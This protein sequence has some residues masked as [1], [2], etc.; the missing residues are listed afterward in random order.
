[1]KELRVAIVGCGRMGSERARLAAHLGARVVVVCDMDGARAR[2]L[3]AQYPG[4][5]PLDD[6]FQ[7]CWS[8]LEAVFVCTPP[9]RRGPVELAAIEAGVAVF[10][11]KPVGLCAAQ[12]DPLLVAL[13]R[14]P[15][16]T[17]VGYMNRY[18]RSVESARQVLVN[19]PVLGL[20][21]N[22]VGGM[23]K[24]PWWARRE[25]SG[26]QINEQCTHL[27]DLS[28]YL[29]GEIT[30]VYAWAQQAA[31][32]ADVDTAVS[33]LIRFASGTLGNIFYSCLARTKQIGLQVFTPEGRVALEGWDLALR[34]EGL[35][36]KIPDE[37][38]ET[39]PIFVKEVAAFFA[40]LERGTADGI[41]SD[42]EDAMRT[43][44]VVDAIQVSL[45]SGLPEPGESTPEEQSMSRRLRVAAVF[46]DLNIGGDE[47]RTLNFV[48]AFDRTR[49][50]YTV[51][52]VYRPDT[53]QDNRLGPMREWYGQEGIELL[54]LGEPPQLPSTDKVRHSLSQLPTYLG[55]NGRTLSR[56]VWHLARLLRERRIDVVDAHMSAV[57][58]G[59]LAGR[60]AGVRGVVATHYGNQK[61]E[62][63]LPRIL[64]QLAYRQVDTL[65]S[66]SQIRC[67]EMRSWL[68]IPSLNTAVIPNGVVPPTTTQ[69]GPAMRRHFGL[70]EDPRVRVI[71]QISRLLPF[72]GQRQILAAAPTVLAQKPDTAFLLCGYA[73]DP[74]YRADLEQE[75][76]ALGIADRV[77]IVGYPGPVGDVWA[78]IDVHV[79]ASLHES[80]PVAIAESMALGKAAVVAATGG[81][82]DLVEHNHTGLIV[83]PGQPQPLA[84]A[85]LRLLSEPGLAEQLGQAARQRYERFH[86]PEVMARSL[87]DLFLATAASHSRRSPR[88]VRQ[89]KGEALP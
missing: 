13:H 11:E 86:R 68:R 28:R 12:C 62:R 16:L 83:P 18:R 76:G 60:L 23:Y 4:S 38:A 63:L 43:Q 15:V 37:P 53:E 34:R 89:A 44:R 61:P 17:A 75:A 50:D 52:T 67:D 66:D 33:V 41:K 39:E 19:I 78:A 2:E 65:V 31:E 36:S 48:R 73:P 84:E 47:N 40:A 81:I 77:R 59:S 27:V 5:R 56:R 35:G 45:R 9:M 72:K 54:N 1:M 79:H 20:S 80:S 85:L 70:P 88:P 58:Y 21:G 82:P 10:V 26:G 87:E 25:Q 55:R 71:G 32:A 6:A 46:L 8:A 24:A 49:L 29:V 3:A 7:L 64:T 74:A 14:R 57:L 22:W 42:L 30:D 69:T 51:I